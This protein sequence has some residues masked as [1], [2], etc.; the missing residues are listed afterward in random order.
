[1]TYPDCSFAVDSEAAASAREVFEARRV[2]AATR[3][4][5][6]GTVGDALDVE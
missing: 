4:R 3:A 2:D 5:T 1:V 6:F